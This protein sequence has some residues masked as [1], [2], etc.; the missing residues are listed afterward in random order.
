MGTTDGEFVRVDK[1]ALTG[2][3]PPG[4]IPLKCGVN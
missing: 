2:A 1:E 4:V 3:L